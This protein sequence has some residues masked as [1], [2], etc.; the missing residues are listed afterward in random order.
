MRLVAIF[1]DTPAMP[2]VR[3]QLEPAHWCGARHCPTCRRSCE[4]QPAL[5]CATVNSRA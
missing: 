5:Q 2:D 1:E 3:A 4:R